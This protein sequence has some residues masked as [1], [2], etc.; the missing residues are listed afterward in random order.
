MIYFAT[1]YDYACND[2]KCGRAS[3]T[4]YYY[5]N[6]VGRILHPDYS[7]PNNNYTYQWQW[8][9]PDATFDGYNTYLGRL[10]CLFNL[11]NVTLCDNNGSEHDADTIDVPFCLKIN[12]SAWVTYYHCKT[13]N[14]TMAHGVDLATHSYLKDYYDDNPGGSN[15]LTLLIPNN[16]N[17]GYNLHLNDGGDGRVNLY[18]FYQTKTMCQPS[19]QTGCQV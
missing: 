15:T 3:Y 2:E 11:D 7:Y 17:P 13:G 19:C 9:N 18:R 12:D 10:H 16:P 14:L 5:D 4:G 1:R 8:T 6:H